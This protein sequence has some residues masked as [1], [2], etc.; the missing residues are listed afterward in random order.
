MVPPLKPPVATER[1]ADRIQVMVY[2]PRNNEEVEV[3]ESIMKAA[4]E[5]VTGAILL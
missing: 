5:W 3:V 2:A 1:W 4:V